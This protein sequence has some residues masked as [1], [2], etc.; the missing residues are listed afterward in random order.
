MTDP[1]S[2]QS[3]YSRQHE[4]EISEVQELRRHRTAKIGESTVEEPG[5]SFRLGRT[6]VTLTWIEYQLVR[7]LS[8]RPYRAFSRKQIADSIQSPKCSEDQVDE[9]VRTLRDKLG[10]FS[11]YV[12]SVP[13]IGYRFKP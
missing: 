9:Y 11:D 8:T 10:L 1:F 12:Q 3:S 4:A 6:P 13:Y 5:Y 2:T 7:F